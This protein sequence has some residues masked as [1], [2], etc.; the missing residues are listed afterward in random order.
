M[1]R[2]QRHCPQDQ[3]I[4]CAGKQLRLVAQKVSS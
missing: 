4:E 2:P 3:Q 1:Q